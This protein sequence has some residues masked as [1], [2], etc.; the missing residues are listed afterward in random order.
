[1]PTA[2]RVVL[3]DDHSIVRDGVRVYLSTQADLVI[4]GEAG[5]GD[6][7]MQVV[8]A[9]IPD[10]VVMDLRMPGMGGVEA[11]R[12]IRQRS[13][14]TQV[15]ILT[16]FHDD[17][18]LFPALEAGAIAY[19]LKSVRP[20]EVAAAIRAVARNEAVIPPQL[21]GRIVRRLHESDAKPA[22]NPF[23]VLTDR[24]QDILRLIA[25]GLS[26]AEIAAQLMLSEKTVKG[27]VSN[28]LQ[29]LHLTD[30]TKAAVLAWQA[31]FMQP[32]DQAT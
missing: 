17:A 19:L 5:S 10:V 27:Y 1:M 12:Q 21:L 32:P 4:V 7:A 8:Q 18:D 28:I 31:G 11:T 20:H 14:Q 16:S 22:E 3:V 23:A 2:I 25:Q 9:T 26:N 15:V 29:K 24:E 30:R 13:P 6:E